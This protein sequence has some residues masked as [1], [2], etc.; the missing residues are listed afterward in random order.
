MFRGLGFWLP[1]LPGVWC[2]RR[3]TA[4]QPLPQAAASDEYWVPDSHDLAARLGS[5]PDG[6]SQVEAERRLRTVGPNQL[7]DRGARSRLGVV[8]AQVR[9]PLLLILVFAACASA[10]SGEWIDAAIVLVIVVA[11]VAVGYSREYSAQAAVAAL[12]AQVQVHTTVVRDG[13]TSS[14]PLEE[15][16][17]GDVVVLS[18]GAL[19][20][21]D[22]VI[23]EATDCF[24]SEAVLTGESFPTEKR[25]GSVSPTAPLRE[26]TNSLFLGTSVRSG[27]ARCLI[28][29]TGPATEFGAVAARLSLRP[30][31]TEFDR[32]IRR[33]G[34]LMTI[35]M[36]AL[37]LLVFV[38]HMLRGRPPVETLLFS[39]A[40]AVGLSPELLPAILSVS[41]A[42]GAQMMATHGVIVRRLNAI[43]NLG[44]MNILC[45][46]KT[47]TLT[48]GVVQLEGAY[49]PSGAPSTEVLRL[50]G[51][52]AALE[53]GL[54]NPLD[55]AIL[56]ALRPDLSG[57]RKTGEI[58][59][60]FVR[61]RVSVIVDDDHGRRL[62]TNRPGRVLLV[63][64]VLLV[65]L[66]LIL[67][68]FP[69][70]GA[71]GFVPMPTSLAATICG[72]TLAYVMATEAAKKWFYR[73]TWA[74]PRVHGHPP[75]ADRTL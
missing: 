60:D 62:I 61:K 52:N 1:M 34:Y 45:T 50:G 33:F 4:R 5:G 3:V 35:A 6:L 28:V 65:P 43:E 18:A 55:E 46:D 72:I 11:S 27:T 44:S 9:N 17:P 59:F 7:R 12:Q 67:P 70:V 51:C 73:G 56:Q 30:P 10:L 68:Y 57:P 8:W 26:R 20:P 31:E 14:I 74:I 16:V 24:V 29:R 39:V 58:P 22:G 23:L 64:T 2:S 25:P 47:G 71:L 63:S 69:F 32:G 53:T 66:A 36:L 15:V 40:L 38:A 21:G 41:L 54:S 42:R 37:V 49:D 19:I 48:E 75:L 13:R